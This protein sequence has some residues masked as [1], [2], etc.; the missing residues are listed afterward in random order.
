MV[1]SVLEDPGS[2]GDILVE[3]SVVGLAVERNER[4][5]D[6][7]SCGRNSSVEYESR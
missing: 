1:L 2:K 3:E 7:E 6:V 4:T 5:A